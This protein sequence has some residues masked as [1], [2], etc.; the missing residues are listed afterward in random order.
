MKVSCE[1]MAPVILCLN[2]YVQNLLNSD[3]N[4]I[5]TSLNQNFKS[6]HDEKNQNIA[7]AIGLIAGA[8][9]KPLELKK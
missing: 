5:F 1:F 6:K 9:H 2:K 8:S 7:A 3:L 4:R